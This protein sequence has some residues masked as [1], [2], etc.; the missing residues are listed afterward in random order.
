MKRNFI[1]L[2][3]ILV[4]CF[5]SMNIGVETVEWSL[6]NIIL[7]KSRLP[8]TISVIISGFGIT[9]SGVIFQHISRN[10]F[11]SPSTSGTV[12]GAQLGIA[13]SMVL[14]P[15]N[16]TVIMM[17]FAFVTSI[18]T[19]VLFMTILGHLKLKEIIFIPLL[20]IMLG[21]VI[22]GITTLLAYKFNF[23]QIL[24]GWFYG[25]FS[26]VVAGRFEM[27]YISIPVI[28]V[29]FFYAKAFSI[30]GLGRN[31]SINL[32]LNYRMVV[33]I[34][35]I[36]ISVINASVVIVVGSIPFLG[37]V[38]PNI[39]SI[40]LGDNLEKN[41]LTLGLSGALFLLVCDILAR[42][43]RAPFEIPVGLIVG[44]I[45]CITFIYLILRREKL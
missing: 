17:F 22:K 37:L 21:A 26:L 42:T 41:L 40:Y 18:L 28:I 1:L 32:G 4:A 33:N 30:A 23:L 25:S 20:G 36:I 19:T 16:S 31:F 14:F 10:K 2:L 35:L 43:L 38:I 24:E 11:V 13:I 44:I 34:G 7:M 5:L 15:S 39:G 45:G 29:A 3:L 6:S 9:M 8:R 27:L 12:S